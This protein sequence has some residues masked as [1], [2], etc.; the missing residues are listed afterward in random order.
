VNPPVRYV[1][2]D[3]DSGRWAGFPFRPG[4]IVISTRSKHGTTWAQMICAVLVCGTPDLPE[5][6]PRLSPWVDHTVQPVEQVLARLQA[7]RHR[8]FVKTH[9]P[10]DGIPL[11]GRVT[12]LVVGRHPLDAAVSLYH[13]ADNIDRPRWRRLTGQPE[14]AQPPPPRA[15]LHDW[16]VAWVDRSDDP[17]RELDS[18]P[19][20]AWHLTDAWA[21]RS[22][23]NVVLLHYADLERDLAGEMRRLAGRLR[24]EA[25]AERWPALVEAAGFGSMR[26]NTSVTA[27]NTASILKDPA[28]FFR[29]GRSGAGREVLTPA[30]Y[31]RYEERIAGL[32]PA[33]LVPWLHGGWAAVGGPR[34]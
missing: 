28:V 32:V 14:P 15:S 31:A 22:C 21:R 25:P 4:D 13:Q 2:A 1:S 34:G 30:E 20:V 19:G 17:R 26:A 29:R 16:L 24:I 27:P 18:L 10:L 6:L 9:T 23:P 5:P 7:Q 3:E 12:Y 8:R 33:D 11:D